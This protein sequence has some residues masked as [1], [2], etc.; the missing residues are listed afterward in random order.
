MSALLPGKAG[1]L[2]HTLARRRFYSPVYVQAGRP[3]RRYE[4]NH[5]QEAAEQLVKWSKRGPGWHKAM[6]LCLSALE[7]DPIDPQVIRKAFEAAA[8]EAGMLLRS[9][10]GNASRD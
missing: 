7:G 9:D 6:I 10:Q 3:D 2:N 1:R 8:K 4:V 5:V